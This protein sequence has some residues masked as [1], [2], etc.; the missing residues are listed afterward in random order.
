MKKIIKDERGSGAIAIQSIVTIIFITLLSFV[1]MN[2]YYM[3]TV[4]A[5][6]K[7]QQ[8]LANRAVYAAIDE[9]Q[10]AYRIIYIDETKGREI[11]DY[12]L[13]KNL[14][15]DSLNIPGR[16]LG[17]VG[18]VVVK[19]FEIYNEAELPAITPSGRTVNF[20]SVYSE[21]EIEMKPLL[22]GLFGSVKFN[23]EL[24]TDIPDHMLKTFHP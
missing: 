1:L 12:Y 19:N 21:I 4:K 2:F 10:L 9:T 3:S 11:F 17:L 20:I 13:R 24:T 16:D 8:D 15:L 7:N 22:F 18:S 14:D 5:F 6:V 23:P